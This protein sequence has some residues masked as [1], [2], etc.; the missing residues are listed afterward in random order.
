MF[1]LLVAEDAGC[2]GCE[3]LGI[4]EVVDT[5]SW[6]CGY[7]RCSLFGRRDDC[8]VGCLGCWMFVMWYVLDIGCLECEM[9]AG[10]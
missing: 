7:S 1:E 9:F 2:W 4:R 8:Y 5:R 3:N 6:R 10:C